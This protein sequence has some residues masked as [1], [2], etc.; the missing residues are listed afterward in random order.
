MSLHWL[1]LKQL[2]LKLIDMPEWHILGQPSLGPYMFLV[3]SGSWLLLAFFGLWQPLSL[4]Q[5]HT[6]F[7]VKVFLVSFCLS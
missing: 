2:L 6:T 7:S 3:S 1:F 4:L 5:L